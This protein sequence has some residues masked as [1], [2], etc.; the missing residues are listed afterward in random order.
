M[1]IKVC[2]CCMKREETWCISVC[3]CAFVWASGV[4]V[5]DTYYTVKNEVLVQHPTG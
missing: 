5:G 4:P 1:C 3:M 2:A